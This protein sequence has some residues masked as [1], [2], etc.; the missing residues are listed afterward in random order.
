MAENTEV[1]TI[2]V[3]KRIKITMKKAKLDIS[4]EVREYLESRSKSLELHAMLKKIR[5][6]AKKIKIN[7][8]SAEIIRHY[9]DS[10]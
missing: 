1:I 4:K 3:P 6:N 10:R 7:E 8:S 9:R 2:R 5:K